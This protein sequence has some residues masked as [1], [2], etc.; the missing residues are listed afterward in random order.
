MKEVSPDINDVPEDVFSDLMILESKPL[1]LR[2]RVT[3]LCTEF[4]V[5]RNKLNAE[6]DRLHDECNK[7]A[8][9]QEE[10]EKILTDAIGGDLDL[11]PFGIWA[12][13]LAACLAASAL[14]AER[15]SNDELKR[16]LDFLWQSVNSEA[17]LGDKTRR[18]Y[19]VT[20]LAMLAASIAVGVASYFAGRFSL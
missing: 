18:K 2:N 5:A 16:D 1:F 17:D 15:A 20:M 6:I 13:R 7:R 11:T 10:T 9:V 12:T 4:R 8:K 14:R 3:H 19:A